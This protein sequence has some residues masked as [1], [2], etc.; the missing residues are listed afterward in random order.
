MLRPWGRTWWLASAALALSLIGCQSVEHCTPGDVGCINGP[1]D[2]SGGCKFDLV[3]RVGY[4]MPREAAQLIDDAG[5][6]HFADGALAPDTGPRPPPTMPCGACPADKTCATDSKSCVDFCSA[7]SVLPGSKP[8][9]EA[10]RCGGE[11]KNAETGERYVL[12]FAE[13]CESNCQLACRLR[14][15][16]CK[17]GCDKDAC[18]QPEVQ[19][20]CH[21]RCDKSSDPLSC[22]QSLCNDTRAGGCSSLPGFC[23][24]G[25][26]PDCK[27]A[28]CTNSCASTA[29]DG[30]C[31]DGDLLSA[32]FAGCAWGTDCS[33]CGPRQGE[34]TSR[35][36][37]QGDPCSLQEQCAGSS[38]DFMKNSAFCS[39]VV[40]GKAWK[41]CV[42]DCSTF[43]KP[44]PVGTTCTTLK[45]GDGKV[46]T[47]FNGVE[48][49]ACLPDACR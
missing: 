16:F 22:V 11:I 14:S 3:P 32:S 1:P 41:R 21:T 42:L 13:T 19:A 34:D 31:D 23:A 17:R 25:D 26:S 30:V 4:C 39:A 40:P 36:R 38:P 27:T 20:D 37:K 9:A 5:F 47:D 15:W 18:K 7:P 29:Y 48:G 6:R 33:D 49:H 43:R 45:L 2:K 44:C 28:I 35:N 46:V 10:I 12:T 24:S 8:T